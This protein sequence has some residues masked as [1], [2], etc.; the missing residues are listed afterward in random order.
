MTG[1]LPVPK[2]AFVATDRF[3]VDVPRQRA[4]AAQQIVLT[5]AGPGDR[6]TRRR[7][8][9]C[10]PTIRAIVLDPIRIVSGKVGRGL[11][12]CAWTYEGGKTEG[13]DKP[14]RHIGTSPRQ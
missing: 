10:G 9:I 2:V 1:K 3:A 4:R 8:R 5:S 7:I 12:Q 6:L 11:R 14:A 13:R